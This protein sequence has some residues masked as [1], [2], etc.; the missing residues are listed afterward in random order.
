MEDSKNSAIDFVTTIIDS[1]GT[2]DRG[3]CDA[4]I[5]VFMTLDGQP[6]TMEIDKDATKTIM[7]EKHFTRCDQGGA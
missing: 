2:V 6:V 7:P 5:T 1:V 4:H 3:E